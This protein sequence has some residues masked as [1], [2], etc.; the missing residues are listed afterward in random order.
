MSPPPPASCSPP[1]SAR[2]RTFSFLLPRVCFLMLRVRRV[3]GLLHFSC[4]SFASFL[5]VFG[6]RLD[7]ITPRFAGVLLLLRPRV[8]EG[9]SDVLFG[10]PGRPHAHMAEVGLPSLV[11]IIAATRATFIAATRLSHYCSRKKSNDC[12]HEESAVRALGTFRSHRKQGLLR[13]PPRS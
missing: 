13:C 10:A 6:A 5:H 11:A 7:V 9:C 3:A 12:A 1:G 8:F 4:F 2:R